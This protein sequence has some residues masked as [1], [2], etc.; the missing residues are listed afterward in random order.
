MLSLCSSY[1]A[2]SWFAG[3]ATADLGW[4]GFVAQVEFRVGTRICDDQRPYVGSPEITRGRGPAVILW[5]DVES[6][7]PRKIRQ[8]AQG[9]KVCA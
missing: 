3:L 2:V 7:C 6:D 8:K 9:L 5:A 4:D 1:G